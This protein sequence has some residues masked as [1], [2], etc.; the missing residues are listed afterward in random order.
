MILIWAIGAHRHKDDHQLGISFSCFFI[1]FLFFYAVSYH[2]HHRSV[3]VRCGGHGM[4][5]R[6]IHPIFVVYS[7]SNRPDVELAFAASNIRID[8]V[9]ITHDLVLLCYAQIKYEHEIERL[10][11]H[12]AKYLMYR[13]NV[14]VLGY[15]RCGRVRP[16]HCLHRSYWKGRACWAVAF[17]SEWR[18]PMVGCDFIRINMS[19]IFNK[20]VIF[21]KH[22]TPMLVY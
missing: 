2:D 22:E 17:S 1:F 13:I 7:Y 20:S 15:V 5:H 16:P 6:S 10:T 21:N 4:G 3:C 8:P 12:V 19:F 14:F 9:A 18:W 11:Q